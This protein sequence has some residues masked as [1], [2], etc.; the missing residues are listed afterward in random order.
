MSNR[1]HHGHH[2]AH[3]EKGVV[4]RVGYLVLVLAALALMLLGK[5]DVLV[6]EKVR[7]TISDGVAPV[8]DVLSRPA[9]TADKLVVEFGELSALRDENT[10]LRQENARLLEWQS[11]ARKLSS[12]NQQL[13]GLLN[14]APGAEPGFI[15]GRV[16][17]DSGGAFVHSVLLNAGS[18]DGVAKG[19]AAVTGDGLVGRVHGVGSR[20]GRVLLITD[21]N[22]RIPVV[23]EATRTRAVLAGNNSDRPRLIHMPPGATVSVGDR[24]VTSGHGG[25]FPPG[26]PVGVVAQSNEGNISVKPYV[27]RDR[28]EYVRVVDYG[29]QGILDANSAVEGAGF[30]R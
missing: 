29:L 28:I 11:A 13:K 3:A 25:A 19:Q 5:A 6:M 15:T 21:L 17:A 10:R 14:F 18:R 23:V 9:A 24:I 30:S 7:A 1:Q 16:I 27:Q 22:S 12:E 20:S 8:L 2:L 4:S 26:I